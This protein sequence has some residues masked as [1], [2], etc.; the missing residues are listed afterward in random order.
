MSLR[1]KWRGVDKISPKGKEVIENGLES[2]G[3]ISIMTNYMPRETAE[4]IAKMNKLTLDYMLINYRGKPTEHYIFRIDSQGILRR[5]LTR[6][7]RL[8]F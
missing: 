4:R 8:R 2:L 6:R 1:L 5:E 3:Q 7:R